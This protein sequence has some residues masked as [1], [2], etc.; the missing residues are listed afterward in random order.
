M[1][2]VA[3]DILGPF[4]ESQIGN[5]YVLVVSN[6]LTQWVEVYPIPNQEAAT[7]AKKLTEN[8]IFL[9]FTR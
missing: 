4:P 2:I 8:N 1:Q 6:Y 7:I 3:V 5:S 9:V